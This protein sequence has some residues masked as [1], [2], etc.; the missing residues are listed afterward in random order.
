MRSFEKLRSRVRGESFR[1]RYLGLVTNPAYIIRR[2]LWKTLLEFAPLI[3]GNVLDFG[4]GSKPYES[5]FTEAQTYTGVDIEVSGHE[6]AHS[7]VDIYYNGKTLPLRNGQFDA[8]VS[9]E[10]FE[11]VFNLGDVL[12]EIGRVTKDSGLLL[13]SIPFAWP[14]HEAPYDFARY[15]SFGITHLLSLYGF[16]VIDLR[17]TTTA[18]LAICQLFLAYL[19]SIG[20][21][22]GV[23]RHLYQA[24]VIGPCIIGAYAL[25]AFAPKRYDHFSNAVV[26]AKKRQSQTPSAVSV[27]GQGISP[28]L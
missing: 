20:P 5:L 25:N 26:L 27:S 13:V 3:R 4:C 17:K 1:P 6:H 2:A 21:R 24:A 8:V 11:H 10:V 22:E 14:E 15:T 9:F 23:L 19:E 28:V 16:E 7:K 12:S 18:V